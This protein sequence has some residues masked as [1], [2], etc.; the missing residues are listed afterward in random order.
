MPI[1]YRVMVEGED[2]L[3]FTTET[4]LEKSDL[5]RAIYDAHDNYP[6]AR[7]VWT[8][9]VRDSFSII[10]RINNDDEQDLY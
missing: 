5:T 9:H 10:N 1:L 8:E 6:E 2:G 3:I 4:D 7:S